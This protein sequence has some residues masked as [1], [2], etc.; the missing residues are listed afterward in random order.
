MAARRQ[1]IGWNRGPTEAEA[2]DADL[3]GTT[4]VVGA[5]NYDTPDMDELQ[6]GETGLPDCPIPVE[7]MGTVRVDELPCRSGGITTRQMP[8]NPNRALLGED[9]RRKL[10]TIV[11]IS[12]DVRLGH[13]QN[14]AM[15]AGAGGVWPQSVP[16]VY[17]SSDEL[18]VAGVSATVEVTVVVEN[19]AR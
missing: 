16:F 12:G 1:R 11:P 10:A 4:T 18:W 5:Y 8:T 15:T 14:E 19:W 13:T 7:V 17:S 3:R 6:Q 2:E 9:A